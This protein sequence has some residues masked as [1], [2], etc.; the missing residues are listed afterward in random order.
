MCS[1]NVLIVFQTLNDF[2]PNYLKSASLSIMLHVFSSISLACFYLLYTFVCFVVWWVHS[3]LQ[4]FHFSLS[5]RQAPL[6]HHTVEYQSGRFTV[7]PFC[8]SRLLQLF[9]TPC[10]CSSACFSASTKAFWVCV[11]GLA[12]KCVHDSGMCLCVRVFVCLL[13]CLLACWR[14][15]VKVLLF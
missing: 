9:V 8:M 3:G 13:T 11:L 2:Q 15:S 10:Q 12:C 6:L 14:A 4:D 7:G 5:F 1:E